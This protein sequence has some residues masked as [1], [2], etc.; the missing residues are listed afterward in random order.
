MDSTFKDFGAF[1]LSLDL[2]CRCGEQTARK[3]KKK[4]RWLGN[5]RESKKR[6]IQTKQ[7]N[8]GIVS[9][10][11]GVT[12]IIQLCGR[13]WNVVVHCECVI[14]YFLITQVR[15]LIISLPV[16]LVPSLYCSGLEL[17]R[18]K[19]L[20]HARP[21]LTQYT[22]IHTSLLATDRILS[23]LRMKQRSPNKKGYKRKWGTRKSSW[24]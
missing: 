12:L 18:P 22:A 1:C 14:T 23:W 13:N 6:T 5:K 16:R 7:A 20:S 3:R 19:H 24:Y 4:G 15:E 8:N 9:S 10:V 11:M 17:P 2:T 21:A